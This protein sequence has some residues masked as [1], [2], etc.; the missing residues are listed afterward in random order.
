M[1]HILWIGLLIIMIMVVEDTIVNDHWCYIHACHHSAIKAVLHT[2]DRYPWC[3]HWISLSRGSWES[4]YGRVVLHWKCLYISWTIS[5][6]TSLYELSR[7]SSFNR[8][9]SERNSIQETSL[10]HYTSAPA[11]VHC[12]PR[13][14]QEVKLSQ[15]LKL[16]LHVA[17]SVNVNYNENLKSCNKWSYL[18]HLHSSTEPVAGWQNGCSG[19]YSWWK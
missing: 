6:D 9:Q 8:H 1:S 13:L 3:K 16:L 2:M 10:L 5:C 12:T 7:R 17:H 11:G 14:S 19:T 15:H 4:E 18:V